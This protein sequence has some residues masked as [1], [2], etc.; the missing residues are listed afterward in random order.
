VSAAAPLLAVRGLVKDYPGV[1]ALD[2]VDMT[3]TAGQVHC[4][5]G[6]NGA[7]KSTLIK[8][9]TG[10]V[11]PSAGEIEVDGEPLPPNDP[12]GALARGVAATARSGPRRWSASWPR[13]PSRPCR[14]PGRSRGTPA[15]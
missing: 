7:G 12:A 10:L 15:C 14:W 8:C 1:R 13:R 9:I 3:V 11:V 4:L 6:Q 2:G 5:V